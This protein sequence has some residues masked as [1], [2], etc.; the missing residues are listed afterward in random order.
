MWRQETCMRLGVP[1]NH[2]AKAKRG[3]AWSSYP[4]GSGRDI[5]SRTPMRSPCVK[6]QTTPRSG[7][8]LFFSACSFWRRRQPASC[9]DCMS[10]C[11]CSGRVAAP[12]TSEGSV[13]WKAASPES[14]EHRPLRPRNVSVPA[15]RP[16]QRGAARSP[17]ASEV[18]ARVRG[19]PRQPYAT[20]ATDHGAGAGV[21]SQGAGSGWMA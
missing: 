5:P 1:G 16:T 11:R 3:R 13:A 20:L 18:Q 8:W 12:H 21:P 7:L 4:S 6:R 14:G 15:C 2:R 19:S 10:R 9:P 17:C